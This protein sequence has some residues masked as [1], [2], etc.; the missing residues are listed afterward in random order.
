MLLI[1]VGCH[2]SSVPR[3]ATLSW[4]APTIN[5]DGTPATDLRG[6]KLYVGNAPRRYQY[7]IDVGDRTSYV[8]KN[9]K[10]RTTYFFAVTAYDSAGSE[11]PYSDEVS[12]SF[13]TA[14]EKKR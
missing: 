3:T 11:S 14:R 1:L 13:P 4:V 5:L 2:S 8:L 6:Y 12:K 7:N 10:D 9:L